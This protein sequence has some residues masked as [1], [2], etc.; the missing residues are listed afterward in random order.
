MFIW[1]HVCMWKNEYTWN[2]AKSMCENYVEG[3]ELSK[4]H[5]LN[6]IDSINMN[7][8]IAFF[9]VRYKQSVIWHVTS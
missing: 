1:L 8:V 5:R 4:G 6:T 7:I 9:I 3:C 2:K